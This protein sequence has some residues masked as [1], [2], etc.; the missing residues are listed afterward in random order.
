MENTRYESAHVCDLNAVYFSISYQ[1]SNGCAVHSH[2]N[3]FEIVSNSLGNRNWQARG[4]I[5]KQQFFWSMF[6]FATQNERNMVGASEWT[7]VR[8]L[9]CNECRC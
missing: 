6:N 7:C 3:A 9:K 1:I 4:L 5:C 8:N 2:L